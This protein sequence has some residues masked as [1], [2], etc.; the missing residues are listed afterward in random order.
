MAKKNLRFSLSLIVSF[1][2]SS[3][4]FAA[5]FKGKVVAIHD[6]DTINITLADGKVSRVRLLGTD[7]PEVDVNGHTQGEAATKARDYLRSLLPI[8][9]AVIVNT[10]DEDVTDKHNRLLGQVVFEQ[11]DLNKEMLRSGW[12]VFYLIAPFDKTMAKIY[13]ATSK[14]AFEA[15][16]GLYSSEFRNTEIPY[17]FRL[18]VMGGVGRNLV[19]NIETKE[20]FSQDHLEEIPVYARLFFPSESSAKSRGYNFK[21]R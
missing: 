3:S 21:S 7:S 15:A 9:A 12:S 11:M 20:L 5:Q 10:T 16:R 8:G 4:V 18:R 1:L 6:G 17:Q 14:E 2:I 19:G 13:S